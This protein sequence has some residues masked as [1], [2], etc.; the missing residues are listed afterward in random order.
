M[1]GMLA[2]RLWLPVMS[3]IL[4]IRF[5]VACVSCHAWESPLVT[6]LVL[7]PSSFGCAAASCFCT[8]LVIRFDLDF[9]RRYINVTPLRRLINWINILR[10]AFF[11]LP[12]ILVFVAAIDD[13]EIEGLF[14]G[15][16]RATLA[17]SCIPPPLLTLSLICCAEWGNVRRDV[18]L[19]SGKVLG[20]STQQEAL[21][22]GME[23]SHR[24]V[25][26]SCVSNVRVV[27]VWARA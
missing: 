4:A 13:R 25:C 24:G 27:A 22:H 9:S 10:A 26:G 20:R 12:A 23:A 1:C 7:V 5:V 2:I 18:V 11:E 15:G 19:V 6:A 3:G 8:R 17:R 21:W 14:E 16:E